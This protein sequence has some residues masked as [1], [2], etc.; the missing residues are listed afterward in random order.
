MTCTLTFKRCAV[1]RTFT[2]RV[3]V[4]VDPLEAEAVAQRFLTGRTPE[5]LSRDD[6]ARRLGISVRTLNRHMSAGRIKYRKVGRRAEFVPEWIEAFRSRG[7]VGPEAV[8]E[9]LG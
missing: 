7:E 9:A 5:P 4:I 8:Q 3:E 2:D 6:A 1:I